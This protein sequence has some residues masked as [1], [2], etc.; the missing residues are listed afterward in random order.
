MKSEMEDIGTF[1]DERENKRKGQLLICLP[2]I[3]IHHA[4]PNVTYY[5][6]TICYIYGIQ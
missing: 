1:K 4:G 3:L 6:S 2:W 5:Q